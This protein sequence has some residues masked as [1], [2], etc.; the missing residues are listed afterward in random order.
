MKLLVGSE[1]TS[2]PTAELAWETF[3]RAGE[4]YGFPRQVLTDWGTQS[5][6]EQYEAVGFFDRK[7]R[8]L[9]RERGIRVQH[10]KGRRNHPQTGG[11]V[12]RAIGTIKSRLEATWPDGTR[13]Y[14]DLDDVVRWYNEVKPHESL[15]FERAETPAQAFVRKLRPK[16]RRAVL[17]RNRRTG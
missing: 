16:E 3:L 8:D 1:R 5:T 9:A 13:K 4:R 17:K 6:K 7:L 12:E 10:I 2:H 11:K 15:D 14:R